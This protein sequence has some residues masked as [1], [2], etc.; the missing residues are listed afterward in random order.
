MESLIVQKNFTI[1]KIVLSILWLFILQLNSINSQEQ[2]QSSKCELAGAYDLDGEY[3]GRS[4]GKSGKSTYFHEVGKVI[5]FKKSEQGPFLLKQSVKA[6]EKSYGWEWEGQDVFGD[7]VLG[8]I[9]EW[10]LGHKNGE[11]LNEYDAFPHVLF[12]PKPSSDES[13]NSCLPTAL[14]VID[15]IPLVYNLETVFDLSL[16]NTYSLVVDL[17]LINIEES[18]KS[19]AK[20]EVLIILDTNKNSPE[21]NKLNINGKEKFDSEDQSFEN[22]IESY[23]PDA[24]FSHEEQEYRIYKSHITT[25]QDQWD[26]FTFIIK[27]DKTTAEGMSEF[28]T[29][30]K[31]LC[32]DK[33]QGN[34]CSYNETLNIKP[35]ADY[36]V[37]Y[38]VE[39]N[40]HIKDRNSFYLYSIALGNRIVEGKG[41]TLVSNVEVKVVQK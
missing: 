3:Q 12:G 40:E 32:K 8:N 7:D 38:L 16:L 36:V 15:K 19:K 4:E 27:D 17:W 18:D 34:I 23:Q 28:I 29:G 13:I 35:F 31:P 10:F 21:G 39:N 20:T 26:L 41:E 22:Y 1:W 5:D 2:N 9:S 33:L 37:D 25:P 24:I 30:T 11:F 14:S 6:N